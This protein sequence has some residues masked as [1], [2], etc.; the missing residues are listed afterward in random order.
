MEIELTLNSIRR[1]FSIRER[2]LLLELLRQEGCFSVKHG[3]ETGTCGV[4]AVLF[5]GR[6]VAACMLIAEQA[7]GHRVET[8]E[9]LNASRET[10]ILQQAFVDCGGV[11]CGYC[12]PAMVLVATALLAKTATPSEPEIRDALAAVLCRC[13]GYVKP[14]EAV[15]R[16]SKLT[17]E[18]LQHA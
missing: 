11:Q 8:L 18:A 6:P 10:Q 4:C 16:A 3:C 1:R 13:T 7:D 12:T 14:V 17:P 5:D 15:L 9:G 2:M